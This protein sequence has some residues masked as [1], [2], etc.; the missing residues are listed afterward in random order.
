MKNISII[1][2]LGFF[3]GGPLKSQVPDPG[4]AEPFNIRKNSIYLEILGNGALY[5]F[6]Y[7]RIIP[8]KQNLLLVLRVGGNEY[9]G[10]NSEKLSFNFIGTGGIL[11]GSR[12]HFFES[13]LGFTLFQR[14]PD[15][16]ITLSS[17]YRYQGRK[18]LVIRLTPMYIINTETGDVFGN[19][20]WFGLS[21]GYSF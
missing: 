3:V 12:N 15:F 18:G 9:H 16:L 19:S 14:E 7:D 1:L 2:V 17:G 4:K 5:S 20:L 21:V 11:L 10:M 8:L 13:S 6:N